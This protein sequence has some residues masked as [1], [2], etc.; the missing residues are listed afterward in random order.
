M[1]GQE[2][3]VP[4]TALLAHLE[5]KLRARLEEQRREQETAMLAADTDPDDI[6]RFLEDRQRVIDETLDRALEQMRAELA[7]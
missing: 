3:R 2:K 4:D 6:E 5:R 1:R 7:E